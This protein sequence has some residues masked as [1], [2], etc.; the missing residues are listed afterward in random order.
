VNS[1]SPVG[2][3]SRQ[4]D[5]H[6]ASQSAVR[7]RWLSLCTVW[8]SHSQL[9]S[10]SMAIFVFGKDRS[11]REPNLGCRGVADRPGWCDVLLKKPAL[12]L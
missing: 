1:Y 3:V 9:S 10:F 12:E 6:G 4:W 8:P 2:L 7:R 5:F 11:R